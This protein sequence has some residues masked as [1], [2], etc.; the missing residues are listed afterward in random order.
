M[1]SLKDI[2]KGTACRISWIVGPYASFLRDY[3]SMNENGYIEVMQNYSG[4]LI[5]YYQGK[6]LAMDY[7]LANGIKVTEQPVV[8]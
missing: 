8:E 7:R 5:I 2:K 6:S 4:G 3:F 1:K